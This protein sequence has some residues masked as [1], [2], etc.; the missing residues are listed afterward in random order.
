M[1]N[2]IEKNFARELGSLDQ[3]FEVLEQISRT[4][5]LPEGSLYAFKLCIEELFVNMV[6]YQPDSRHPVTLKMIIEE[7]K[8]TILLVDHDVDR[9]DVS[10][11][12]EVKKDA[13]LEERKPGGLGI[14]LVHQLMDR[15]LYD[16]KDRT[17]TVTLIKNL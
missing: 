12:R 11:P 8:V 13:P 1:Q 10:R 3:V 6:R 5:K 15:V 16:Y 2:I 4:Y 14:Y 17:S 7:N 9:F